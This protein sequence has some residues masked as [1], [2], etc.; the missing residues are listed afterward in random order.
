MSGFVLHGKAAKLH[1]QPQDLLLKQNDPESAFK[2]GLGAFVGV[3]DHPAW[4]TKVSDLLQQVLNH[5]AQ[6][7]EHG[8]VLVQ[9]ALGYLACARHG[10]A[11]DELLDVISRDEEVMKDFIESSPTEKCKPKQEQIKFLPV[12]VWVR[13]RGDLDPYLAERDAQ[14]ASLLNFY[15]RSFLDAVRAR[16]LPDNGV[17]RARHLALAEYFHEQDNWRE[18]LVAQRVR[19]QTAPPTSRPANLR[20]IEE[21]AWQRLEVLRATPVKAD[22]FATACTAIEELLLEVAL[23]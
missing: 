8:A 7:E 1:C 9:R 4:P 18:S 6:P 15:H 23:I 5:L 17:T 10:L 21:L 22:E 11:E 20:K 3:T 2:N 14:G 12:A 13:L 16:C 19:A